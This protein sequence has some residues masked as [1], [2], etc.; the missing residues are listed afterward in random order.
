M[1]ARTMIRLILGETHVVGK[2]GP[3]LRE[4]PA[5]RLVARSSPGQSP[6]LL[7]L[8]LEQRDRQARALVNRGVDVIV[9]EPAS[10][11][12]AAMGT[13]LMDPV[14]WGTVLEAAETSVARQLR[15]R[16]VATR[17]GAAR[18]AA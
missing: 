7:G 13:N 14:R 18:T 6:I 11:D 16:R 4:D 2:F 3:R 1:N 17:L 8:A 5:N 12:R 10:R 15:R 9:V